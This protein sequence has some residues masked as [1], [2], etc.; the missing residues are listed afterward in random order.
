MTKLLLVEDSRGDARLFAELLRELPRQPFALTTVAT[1][2][3]ALPIAAGHDVVFLDLSLPDSHGL[4]GLTALLSVAKATPVV[5]LTGN[6]DDALA[7]Q[8]VAAGAQDYL[9]KQDIS[10]TLIERVASYAIERTK[11]EDQ[12]RRLAIIH[13]AARRAKLLSGVSAAIAVSFDLEATLPVVA[14]LLAEELGDVCTID[15]LRDG[16]FERVACM[17]AD[18]A[19]EAL[20]SRAAAY[21]PGPRHPKAAAL[22]AVETRAQVELTTHDLSGY[23]PDPEAGEIADRLGVHSL[24]TTPLVARGRVLGAMSISLCTA[25]RAIDEEMRQ[26]ASTAAEHI[27]MGIDNAMLYA[28]AQRAIRAR[29]ELIAVVSHDLRNP[30]GVV[31]LALQMMEHDPASVT[32][33][34]PRAQRAADRM[35]RLIEDLLDIARIDNGTLRVDLAD[36]D[37]GTFIDEAYEHHKALA[38]AK[39]ITLVRQLDGFV[40]SVRADHNRLL[41]AVG[42]LVGNALKFTPAGGTIRLTAERRGERVAIAVADSGAGI[43]PEHLTHIFDRYW[44]RDRNQG[45]IGLGLAIVKGIVDAHGGTVEVESTPGV[46]TTFSLV[47]SSTQSGR[48]LTGPTDAPQGTAVLQ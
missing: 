25:A 2:A 27:A 26:L 45:G 20:L 36:L 10:A 14:R 4:A 28:S 41:Q 7:R 42:N 3:E 43:A 18:P 24:L 5:V 33:S 38:T 31:S 39:G 48:H 23:Q 6:D 35:Q 47:L 11:S 46:G 8:A 16:E 29:D 15:L 17:P 13:Q 22:R 32:S 37:V 19:H 21:P 44:Q 40:G 30:L 1:L 12:R 9:R 34:L